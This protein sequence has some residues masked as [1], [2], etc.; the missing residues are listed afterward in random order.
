MIP[1]KSGIQLISTMHFLTHFG[2][3]QQRVYPAL[4]TQTTNNSYCLSMTSLL[5]GMS[6]SMNERKPDCMHD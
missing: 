3:L 2:T 1:L 6:E 4:F 5:Q